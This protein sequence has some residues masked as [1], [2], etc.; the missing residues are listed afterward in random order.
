MEAYAARTRAQ[1]LLALEAAVQLPTEAS[2][3]LV[4]RTVKVDL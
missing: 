3:V 4:G 2:G 1:Y